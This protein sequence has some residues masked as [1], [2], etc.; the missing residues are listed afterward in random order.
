M[1]VLHPLH[2]AM[3][4]SNLEASRHFYSDVLGLSEIERPFNFPGLWYALGDYQVHLIVHEAVAHKL[5][6]PQRWGRNAH[7]ALAIA[8]LE[9]TK[10]HLLASG[11]ETQ[12]SASG[13]PAIFVQDPDG[14][15]IELTQ[16]TS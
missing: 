15:V 5:H 1:E 13:R 6:N 10:A 4:I 8:D 11:C 7:I 9:A 16:V 14:N 2:M 3:L 12:E